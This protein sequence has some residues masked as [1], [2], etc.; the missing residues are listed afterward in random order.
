M[1]QLPD[2]P[3]IAR[4]L[5]T[6]YAHPI[7]TQE[8]RICGRPAECY[9]D[10]SGYLCFDCAREEFDNLGDEEAVELLGFEVL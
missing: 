1:K 4:C 8:C 10:T 2:H 5:C 6:G 9:G 7:P 3:D